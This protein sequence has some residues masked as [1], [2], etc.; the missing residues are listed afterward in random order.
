M[1]KIP[2]VEATEV[3]VGVEDPKP[4]ARND[5]KLPVRRLSSP[6]LNKR[7][8]KVSVDL[9][10]ESLKPKNRMNVHKDKLLQTTSQHSRSFQVKI[11]RERKLKNSE[12]VKPPENLEHLLTAN[13]KKSLKKHLV[14]A[15]AAMREVV[16]AD[17]LQAIW[18][19]VATGETIVVK[20][21]LK[22]KDVVHLVV[23]LTS[24]AM[25]LRDHQ[26]STAQ[27]QLTAG[28]EA[29]ILVEVI[30][31]A[32][33]AVVTVRPEVVKLPNDDDLI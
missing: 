4:L 22:D 9:A 32:A 16:V 13:H 33:E 26:G 24:M 31:R 3:V 19:A 14:V 11:L 18:K 8:R 5:L 21:D 28:L 15:E 25:R 20:I 17:V 27:M 7:R 2:E 12:V 29:T 23:A 1:K 10:Q 6:P 30:T